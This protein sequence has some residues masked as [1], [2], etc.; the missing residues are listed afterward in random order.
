MGSS[1][2]SCLIGL[3]VAPI[4]PAPLRRSAKFA[5]RPHGNGASASKPRALPPRKWPKTARLRLRRCEGYVDRVMA[6]EETRPGQE[7]ITLLGGRPMAKQ[8]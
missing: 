4:L 2:Q 3:A 7:K 1:A 6:S 8:R 5:K